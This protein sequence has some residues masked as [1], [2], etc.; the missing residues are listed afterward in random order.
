MP[1][2]W[3]FKAET[4]P[5]TRRGL[6]PPTVCGQTAAKVQ[7]FLKSLTWKITTLDAEPWEAIGNK[8]ASI[9]DKEGIGPDQ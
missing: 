2:N 9:Q 3:W 6:I 7:I 8:K 5:L 4:C 1:Q